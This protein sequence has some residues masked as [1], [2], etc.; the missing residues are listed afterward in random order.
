MLTLN[1]IESVSG[2]VTLVPMEACYSSSELKL[3]E[4]GAHHDGVMGG[5]FF[6]AFGGAAGYK[7][8]VMLAPGLVASP[9]LT[10]VLAA[11]FVAST[12]YSYN[13]K[14]YFEEFGIH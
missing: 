3:I 10:A 13:Y 12:V 8:G 7:L 6:G 5:L 2:A 11:G 14:G 1:E 9:I 4:E